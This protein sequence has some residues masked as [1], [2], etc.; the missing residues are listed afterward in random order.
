[1]RTH[2]TVGWT[3]LFLLALA[4]GGA[5]MFVPGWPALIAAENNPP[6]AASSQPE[7]PPKLDAQV[8]WIANSY[9]GNPAWVPQ[10]V[11]GLFVTP[12]GDLYTNVGWEEGGGQV[13]VFDQAGSWKGIAGYMHGW[14]HAG[15]STVCANAEFVFIGCS[16]NNEG[17]GLKDP[18]TWPP[19]GFYWLGVSRRP[20][21][22]VRKGAPFEG[23]KGGAGDTLKESFLVLAEIPEEEQRKAPETQEHLRG[24]AATEKQLYVSLRRQGVIRVLDTQTMKPAGEFKLEG[25]DRLAL[26]PNGTLWALQ[27]PAKA[28]SAWRLAGLD[29]DSG[30][31]RATFTLPKTVLPTAIVFGPDG[32]LYLADD[33]MDQQIKVFKGLDGEKP[34]LNPA[35]ELGVKGGIFA[36]PVPGAAGDLR[37][38]SPTGI[39]LDKDGNLYVANNGQHGGGGTVL[40]SYAPDGTNRWRRYGLFFVDVADLDPKGMNIYSSEEIFDLDLSKPPGQQWTYRAYTCDARKF[41]DDPRA[42]LWTSNAWYRELDGQPF[43]F[44][45]GMT[46]PTFSV[47]RFDPKKHGYIAIPCALWTRQRI[48]FG[49][50]DWPRHQPEQGGWRWRDA[51]G[52]GHMQADE[53]TPLDREGN[54]VMGVFPIYVDDDGRVWWGFSDEVRSYAF[55]GVDKQG[56][57]DWEWDK[58]V[59]FSRP[60]EFDH[61]RRAVYHPEKNLLIVGGGKGEDKHRHW[62]PMGPVVSAYAGVLEGKPRQV[63]TRILPY[64]A[65]TNGH[66]SQEPIGMAAA[67]DYLFVAYTAGLPEENTRAA[68]VKVLR[69]DTGDV[70]GN[71]DSYDVTGFI[72]LLDVE[73]PV[74]ARKLPDGRYV[75]ILEEDY[76]AKNVMFIWKP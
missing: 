27:A 75:V 2:K 6:K 41:P 61:L 19:K 24:L 68:Y 55:K 56:I 48:T 45:T 40:E 44:M 36:G 58:P 73:H 72:G 30:K 32:R 10:N 37:F 11:E 1:M 14:G 31:V 71:L 53:F 59:I 18:G 15:G 70:V 17:G 54:D 60:E 4:L 51:N 57:P 12:E 13:T 33:G 5:A 21:E 64:V 52:D 25:A 28:D 8:S 74:T 3:A 69:L 47:H 62:K 35:G 34:V 66:T 49:T 76:K 63:W 46:L 23:G 67:G 65:D 7:P 16:M 26:G 39:G 29:P 43:L 22:N 9:P 20:R 38:H 42:R 50:P